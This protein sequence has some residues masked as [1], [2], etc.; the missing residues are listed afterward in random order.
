[1]FN[2][3]K[4]LLIPILMIGIN[5]N[6]CYSVEINNIEHNNQNISTIK[7]TDKNITWEQW[8][9]RAN[10]DVINVNGEEYKNICDFCKQ[11]KL[12]FLKR[13][14]DCFI[15]KIYELVY[16]MIDANIELDDFIMDDSFNLHHTRSRYIKENMCLGDSYSI[17]N[18]VLE[19]DLTKL[20]EKQRK[21][22]PMTLEDVA[23]TIEQNCNVITEQL[24]L[25]K[26]ISTIKKVQVKL[27]KN[28]YP[29]DDDN[30]NDIKNIASHETI[31]MMSAYYYITNRFVQLTHDILYAI[32]NKINEYKNKKILDEELYK[33]FRN[34]LIDEITLPCYK[35]ISHALSFFIEDD[36]FIINNL[37]LYK[38]D[39]EVL[40]KCS[41]FFE[42][43]QDC[44]KYDFLINTKCKLIYSF[45][46]LG[47][48]LYKKNQEL[49]TILE[50][51]IDEMKVMVENVKHERI[52]KCLSMLINKNSYIIDDYKLLLNFDISHGS[53]LMRYIRATTSNNDVISMA[54]MGTKYLYNEIFNFMRTVSL[55]SGIYANYDHN[56]PDIKKYRMAEKKLQNDLKKVGFHISNIKYLNNIKYLFNKYEVNLNNNGTYNI[57]ANDID[58]YNNDG[59]FKKKNNDYNDSDND[60]EDLI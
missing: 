26:V 45:S 9:K 23:R 14:I 41:D 5:S 47:K 29:N 1:M 27:N 10:F 37:G 2:I 53:Y 43:L 60:S 52:E 7:Y 19:D 11:H 32:N 58:K 6:D 12:S 56:D 40:E 51:N 25:K 54:N 30:D 57:S 35:T 59:T 3:I 15:N 13:G 28:K 38:V 24:M 20:W 55:K 39:K 21:N 16:V 18:N 49:I 17:Y 50:R 34:Y 22:T 4:F 48:E 8:T 36:S 46:D 33:E 42:Y 44:W 31:N